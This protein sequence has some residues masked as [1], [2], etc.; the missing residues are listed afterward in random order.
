MLTLGQKNQ[1]KKQKRRKP[2]GVPQQPPMFQA[3]FTVGHTL[4]Y[5]STAALVD[6][7]ILVQTLMR[8]IVMAITTTTTSCLFTSLRIRSVQMWAASSATLPT[9]ISIEFTVNAA[10]GNSVSAKPK[11]FSDT[12]I[13]QMRNA[14]LKAKPDKSSS[15]SMWQTLNVQLAAASDSAGAGF[16][17]NGPIGTVLDLKITFVL[18]NGETPFPGRT[19]TATTLVPGMIYADFLDNGGGGSGTFLL[20]PISYQP[21]P[22]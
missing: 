8:T 21:L 20:S 16:I 10:A 12:S 4:R 5:M 13:G 3:T 17:L 15:C 1:N 18:Q 11:V 22:V 7:Q 9:T 2:K 14:A 19:T 6:T